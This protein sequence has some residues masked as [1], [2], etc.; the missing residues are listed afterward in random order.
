[1]AAAMGWQR[2]N[3]CKSVVELS[4]GCNHMSEYR[5]LPCD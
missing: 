4:T 3:A 5:H 2:C 1:L